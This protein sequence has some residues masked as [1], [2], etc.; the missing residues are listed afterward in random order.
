M[1]ELLSNLTD[2]QLYLKFILICFPHV[3]LPPF[4]TTTIQFLLRTLIFSS[5]NLQF[6]IFLYIYVWNL[7][8]KYQPVNLNADGKRT[9][10]PALCKSNMM[11]K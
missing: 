7:E 11:P 2:T 5:N 4:Q 1:G 10:I 3:T 8:R 6:D 9:C